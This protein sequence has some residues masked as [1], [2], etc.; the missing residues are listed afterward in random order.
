MTTTREIT[1]ATIYWDRQGDPEGWAYRLDYSDGHCESGPWEMPLPDEADAS[2][3]QRAVVALADQWGLT[4]EADEVVAEP[5]VEGGY[6]RWFG[7]KYKLSD[8]VR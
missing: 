2:D 8:A 5:K 6:A 1:E 3:L 4:I 7:P